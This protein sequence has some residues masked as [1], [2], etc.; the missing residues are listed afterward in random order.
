MAA[1]YTTRPL[2]ILGPSIHP[3]PGDHIP[4][5]GFG[6]VNTVRVGETVDKDCLQFVGAIDLL[7]QS[8]FAD[9]GGQNELV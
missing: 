3:S 5:G 6:A 4:P 8:G 9:C 2:G 7:L 1:L